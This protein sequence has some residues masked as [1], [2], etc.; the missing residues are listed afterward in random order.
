MTNPFND[1]DMFQEA[2]DQVRSEAKSR[3]SDVYRCEKL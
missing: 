2:C 1:V 3:Y